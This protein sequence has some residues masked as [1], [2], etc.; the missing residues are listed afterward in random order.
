MSKMNLTT[1]RELVL[2]LRDAL[3]AV[4]AGEPGATEILIE[5]VRV[6]VSVADDDDAYMA[7]L[8]AQGELK[9]L[10]VPTAWVDAFIAAYSVD[11]MPARD[12]RAMAIGAWM[13]GTE[14][15]KSKWMADL[16]AFAAKE[17]TDAL[18]VYRRKIENRRRNLAYNVAHVA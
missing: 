5:A 4:D 10:Q 13:D 7:C 14:D 17:G 1:E 6:I 8:R 3:K 9:A 16:A 18:A 15:C 2:H 11:G 12:K